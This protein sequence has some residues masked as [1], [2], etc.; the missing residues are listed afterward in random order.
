MRI[1]VMGPGGI[2]QENLAAM[3]EAVAKH[4]EFDYE[5]V[6]RA[7]LRGID[8]CKDFPVPTLLIN[9]KV[10]LSSSKL[11]TI[12]ELRGIMTSAEG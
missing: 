8:R 10:E 4:L 1:E 3:V 7:P 9:G 2:K 5:F 6:R 12:A 11:P